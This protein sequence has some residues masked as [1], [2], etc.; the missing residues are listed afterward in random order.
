MHAADLLADLRAAGFDLLPDG[1]LLIVSPASRLTPA[2]REAIRAHKPGLLAC[3][4]GEML[5]E[6]FEERA[7]ALKRGGLP[8][9]EAEANAR[10]STGLLARNLG[11]PW[12]ALRLALSDPAL[13]DSPD[14]VDRPPYGLP[15]WCLTP[16]HKPVQ[17][18]VF[19]VPKRSL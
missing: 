10:A 17:Q 7:A 18:G 19:H 9:E 2:Q 13:P 5:R 1:D 14:P 8:R 12:A 16:D 15:A 6:H 4:W 11:L 3:L